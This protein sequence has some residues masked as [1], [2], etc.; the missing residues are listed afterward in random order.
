MR[1][2]VTLAA[3]PNPAAAP[4]VGETPNNVNPQ[5]LVA[6]INKLS[7]LVYAVFGA[8]FARPA[9]RVHPDPGGVLTCSGGTDF[10]A[11]RASMAT[12]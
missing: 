7:N 11:R 9:A 5:D 6:Q 12:T 8:I 4:A 1:C 10:A 2:S 3:P